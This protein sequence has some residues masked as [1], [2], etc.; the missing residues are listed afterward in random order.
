MSIAASITSPSIAFANLGYDG[1]ELS[2]DDGRLTLNVDISA[3]GKGFGVL[4]QETEDGITD[5]QYVYDDFGPTLAADFEGWQKQDHELVH[6]WGVLRL[7]EA[8]D[9]LDEIIGGLLEST[10]TQHELL[11]A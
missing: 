8:R 10:E 7:E 4:F 9:R 11:K 6:E 2:H 5:S 1:M 3:M